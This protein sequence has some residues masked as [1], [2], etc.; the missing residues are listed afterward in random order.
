MIRLLRSL[1]PG[2]FAL[3]GVSIFLQVL[4][5]TR[6]PPDLDP[7]PVSAAQVTIT[8][9]EIGQSTGTEP[10]RIGDFRLTSQ[11][12]WTTDPD[13][14]TASPT[15]PS[16]VYLLR[17]ETPPGPWNSAAVRIEDA[18]GHP[19][20]VRVGRDHESQLAPSVSSGETAELRGEH[21]PGVQA[22]SESP[23]EIVLRPQ[24]TGERA[25]EVSG[26]TVRLTAEPDEPLQ[27]GY[28][29]V[30]VGGFLPL[31]LAFFLRYMGGSKRGNAVPFGLLI[32]GFVVVIVAFSEPQWLQ[33]LWAAT[34]ALFLGAGANNSVHSVLNP[35]SADPADLKRRKA[36]AVT[37]LMA[38]LICV[39][40]WMRWET[41]EEQRGAPSV[42]PE[43]AS[44]ELAREGLLGEGIA[45][46]TAALAGPLEEPAG[47]LG[48]RLA[49]LA[50]SALLVVACFAAGR[51]LLGRKG[52]LL[53]AALAAASPFAVGR[54]GME[55]GLVLIA[56]SGIPPIILWWW[57]QRYREGIPA[58]IGAASRRGG[59]PDSATAPGYAFILL[60]VPAMLFLVRGL[61]LPYVVLFFGFFLMMGVG[62]RWTGAICA[63]A[64][65]VLLI[66]APEGIGTWVRE[67][68]GALPRS[69]FGD[70]WGLILLATGLVA[71]GGRLQRALS[72]GWDGAFLLILAILFAIVAVAGVTPQAAELAGP[73][74]AA[75]EPVHHVL[76]ALFFPY[77]ALGWAAGTLALTDLLRRYAR[78]QI[79]AAREAAEK[80]R[81]SPE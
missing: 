15:D 66:L 37:A 11:G 13:G 72:R 8:A 38:G 28:P 59:W 80:E 74:A 26:I 48:L 65:V 75:R 56:L 53:M 23:L 78:R 67:A 49:G 42:L 35:K 25:P 43:S 71:Y 4:L 68:L 18:A 6:F 77:V 36:L 9:A 22:R 70:Q 44:V 29:G 33:Y 79:T 55:P 20:S 1:D 30:M 32:G 17:I 16:E 69:A 61:S 63:A 5:L 47:I 14:R 57:A 50:L 3:L 40:L 60:A 41:F 10:A 34:A 31:A 54:M 45:G 39:A 73:S 12:A 52:G 27:P 51:L 58:V 7:G 76:H 46:V 19:W 24:E 81:K 64:S 21:F 2:W 62:A